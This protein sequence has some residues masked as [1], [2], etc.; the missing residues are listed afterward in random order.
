[1]TSERTVC[2]GLADVF[3]IFGAE[4]RKAPVPNDGLCRGT[5]DICDIHHSCLFSRVIWKCD[6][7]TSIDDEAPVLQGHAALC[8]L[9]VI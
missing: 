8:A 6:M 1:M 4:M 3:N 2:L 7:K 9:C 5:C